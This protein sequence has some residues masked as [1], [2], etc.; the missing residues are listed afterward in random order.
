MLT[1][2]G[3]LFLTVF[4]DV[5]A[6]TSLVLLVPASRVGVSCLLI[7]TAAAAVLT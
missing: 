6:S 3:G 2:P 7:L 1:L 5:S 4:F